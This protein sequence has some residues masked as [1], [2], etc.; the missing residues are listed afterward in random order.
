MKNMNSSQG[1]GK[2]NPK[3]GA[4]T[5]LRI[6]LGDKTSLFPKNSPNTI[7]ILT[8]YFFPSL[9]E[10]R[11]QHPSAGVTNNTNIVNVSS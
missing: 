9:A 11:A 2:A 4:K 6:K 8:S 3:L 1:A 10:T 7:S 5:P